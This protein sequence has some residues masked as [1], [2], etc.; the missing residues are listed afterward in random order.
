LGL[1]RKKYSRFTPH[2]FRFLRSRLLPYVCPMHTLVRL[3]VCALAGFAWSAFAA[4]YDTSVTPRPQ[5]LLRAAD[6][7]IWIPEGTRTLRG[8]IIR[9]HGCGTGATVY[10]LTHAHEPQWQALAARHQ[11]ALL[12]TRIVPRAQCDDWYKLEGG[13]DAALLQ[14]L[15]SLARQSG[16]AE[17]P[18]A[19]WVLCGHSGGGAWT[20]NMLVK[21]PDRIAAAVPGRMYVSSNIIA[22][23]TNIPVLYALAA[24]DDLI[25]KWAG[26]SYPPFWQPAGAFW[27]YAM[28][29][30]SGHEMGNLRFMAIPWIDALLA[31]RLPRTGNKLLPLDVTKG[32]YADHAT[33]EITPAA[34]FTGDTT[35]VSW[36]PDETIARRWKE[37]VTT[38][39]I[40][41]TQPPPAP[42]AATFHP[43]PQG[44]AD[45]H[46]Q[47]PAEL[48]NELPAFQ[49]F[50]DGKLAGTVPALRR[51]HGDNPE[52]IWHGWEFHD[53]ATNT[54]IYTVAAL[55]NGKSSAPSAPA[56]KVKAPA[57]SPNLP[58]LEVSAIACE[59]AQPKP[60]ERCTF[61]TTIMNRGKHPTPP[62]TMIGVL[63]WMDGGRVGWGDTNIVLR[64]GE[65]VTVTSLG[66][67]NEIIWTAKPG[68]HTL[69]VTVDDLR[70]IPQASLPP[71][72]GEQMLVVE[73]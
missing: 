13:S 47:Y 2:V 54:G 10:G 73:P 45:V 12:A 70:R 27:A 65:S 39:K 23:V 71:H 33:G 41:A 48:E 11:C 25:Q 43:A 8:V 68:K 63:F 15:A 5:D 9:Q 26:G 69:A 51:G 28:E 6:Y 7:R 21:Y 38:G 50:R 37:Y 40:A 31:R 42:L 3:A 29:P 49:V 35:R 67:P 44:G 61:T 58:D 72:R 57:L 66:A 22:Q 4:F 24:K 18:Q 55:R 64:A 32:W 36:L 60:G 1:Q 17:I 16:H 59:P 46:W 52:P 53:P 14:A 30:T 20:A 62:G 56:K 19:P 34:Q